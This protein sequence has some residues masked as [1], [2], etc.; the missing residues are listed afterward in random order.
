MNANNKKISDVIDSL[1]LQEAGDNS[2]KAFDH[3]STICRL[4]TNSWQV[5]IIL[6]NDD[7]PKVKTPEELREFMKAAEDPIVFITKESF[8]TEDTLE[9]ICIESPL[10]KIIIIEA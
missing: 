3:G 2:K 10:N 8:I 1:A 4:P 7:L 9:K 6:S 5:E